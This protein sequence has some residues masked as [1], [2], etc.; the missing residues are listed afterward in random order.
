[1]RWWL[2]ESLEQRISALEDGLKASTELAYLWN[3]SQ[4]CK[5]WREVRYYEERLQ[6]LN[7]KNIWKN[8][9]NSESFA[10]GK[11]WVNEELD[12]SEES[13]FP[14]LRIWNSLFC[15]PIHLFT[16][17]SPKGQS[18]PSSLSQS[19]ASSSTSVM[20]STTNRLQEQNIEAE[21]SESPKQTMTATTKLTFRGNGSKMGL[22]L[23]FLLKKDSMLS[24]EWLLGMVV[25]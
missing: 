9:V 11:L 16:L 13:E 19:I 24:F 6:H 23:N 7:R 18:F 8:W 22:N 25:N 17:S 4:K 2:K 15:I 3:S 14:S 1:M 5:N 12:S 10:L 20:K 21:K